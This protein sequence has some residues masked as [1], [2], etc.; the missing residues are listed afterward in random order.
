MS[1]QPTHPSSA[2]P[3]A[4]H[5]PAHWR[6][7]SPMVHRAFRCRCSRPVFFGNTRCVS[8]DAELGYEPDS[9]S[10]WPLEPESEAGLYRLH[11]DDSGT[12]Y[13]RC[14]NFGSA[15]VCSWLVDAGDAQGLQQCRS[16]RLNR[17]LP[18][19]S[20]PDNQALWARV[21]GDK[22]RLVA[23]LIAL[24]LPVASRT[25]EDPQRGLAFDLLRGTGAPAPV[26]T[27]HLDGVITLNIDEA[28]DA[29]R[30]AIRAEMREPYR[31]VLGHVRHESG[32]YYWA[33]LVEHGEW[34]EPFRALFG[35]ERADYAESLQRH[36]D[37][38]PPVGW[39]QSFVSAYASAHPWE[40]WAETWAHYLHILDTLDTALSFDVDA[41]RSGLL[42]DP[43]GAGVLF[44]GGPPP[45]EG[46]EPPFLA[47]I[48]AWIELTGVLNELSRSMGERD[49]YP[50][51]LSDAAVTKLH[52][53]HRVMHEVGRDASV[54]PTNS[55]TRT[56]LVQR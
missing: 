47:L 7:L 31:T 56:V 30:E 50:F 26:M 15:M 51:V 48:N 53:V 19:L 3:P 35:D 38:G 10:V 36:H 17:T 54:Q 46:D 41:A 22:Q 6:A 33:R 29:R 32:H 21:E 16:C 4:A 5:K 23:T 11:G 44:R 52:F 18:D 25:V 40:D 34:L 13:R 24:G 27:G 14:A 20:Q 39:Q 37:S 9:A 49:F 12:R 45:R 2:P 1:T 28:D 55:G 42:R 43:F 8:C